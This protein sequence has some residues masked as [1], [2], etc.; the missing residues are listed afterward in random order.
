M[1]NEAN[2]KR[3]IGYEKN[4]KAALSDGTTPVHC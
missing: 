3:N 2:L 4:Y 1:F